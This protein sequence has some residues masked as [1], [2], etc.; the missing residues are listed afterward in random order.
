MFITYKLTKAFPK[1]EAYVLLPQMRRSAI[2]VVANIVEGYIKKSKKEFAR[3]LDISIGSI[4]EL[5]LYFEISS[6][7]KYIDS[8]NITPA[9]NLLLETKKL[10]Y[11]FQRSLK[12]GY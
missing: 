12:A 11:S 7:L 5:E 6:D 2:S 10:L 1:E 3:F 8:K 9:N 4:T